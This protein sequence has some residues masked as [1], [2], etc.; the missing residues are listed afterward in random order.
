MP[1]FSLT[2]MKKDMPKIAKMNITKNSN[3]QMLNKAGND[4]ANA[5]SNVRIPLAPLT[6]RRTRP[7][8]A[9]RTTR[10]KVGDTKYFSMMSL[11]TRPNFR[12]RGIFN[13]KEIFFWFRFNKTQDEH[14]E[15]E[16]RYIFLGE[17]NKI[18]R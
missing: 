15:E 8:L 3:R 5:N 14:I 2:C 16:G 17:T 13:I 7:T 10:S 1:L 6:K 12:W 18:Y 9:T 11:S 4:M